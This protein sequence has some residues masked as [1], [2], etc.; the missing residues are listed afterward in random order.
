MQTYRPGF[1]RTEHHRQH[2]DQHAC[3]AL[4]LPLVPITLSSAGAPRLSSPQQVGA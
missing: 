2:P 3:I 1:H 4:A